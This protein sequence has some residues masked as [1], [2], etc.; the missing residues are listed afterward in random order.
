LVDFLNLRELL[1]TKLIEFDFLGINQRVHVHLKA[2]DESFRPVKW[3]NPKL[4][5]KNSNVSTTKW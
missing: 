3:K 5:E 4:R 2:K 1:E